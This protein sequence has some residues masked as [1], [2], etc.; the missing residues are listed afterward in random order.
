MTLLLALAA[1]FTAILSAVFGMAGGLVLLGVYTALLPVPAAMVLH[2]VTQLVANGS[3]AVLLRRHIAW[4]SV[5][6]YAVG[7]VFAWV[8]LA[9]IHPPTDPAIVLILAGSTPFVARLVPWRPDGAEPRYAVLAG[10]LVQALQVL[11]GVA[12]PLLDVFFIE[13][14]LDRFGIVA[15]KAATQVLSHAAKIGFWAGL[16]DGGLDLRDALATAS[17]AALGTWLGG[18]LLDRIDESTFRKATR[19]IVLGLGGVYVVRGL[20]AVLA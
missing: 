4:R 13:S 9:V 14:K 7:A 2:G 15:T 6:A 3:R 20:F 11:A 16:V 18:H 10:F 5:G 8:L 1:V 17:A 12:G 19:W